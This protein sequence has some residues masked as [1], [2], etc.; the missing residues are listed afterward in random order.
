MLKYHNQCERNFKTVM[1]RVPKG[2][3]FNVMIHADI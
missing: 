1:E 3:E 2:Q